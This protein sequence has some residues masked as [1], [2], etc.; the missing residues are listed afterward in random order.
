LCR[1]ILPLNSDNIHV[2][3]PVY[4][5][6]FAEARTDADLPEEPHGESV[7]LLRRADLRVGLYLACEAIGAGTCAVA[8]YDQ[9]AMDELLR[10]D[11]EKEF[12]IYAA[13]VG[14][15]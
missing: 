13:P 6:G 12:V 10:L 8:A 4:A 9:H 7:G 2:G 15:I 3:P 14:R 11:G 5:F 1:R